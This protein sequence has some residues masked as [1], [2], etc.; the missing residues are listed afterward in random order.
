[1]TRVRSPFVMFLAL[2]V[3]GV[4]SIV[5][6]RLRALTAGGAAAAT[7]V[8]GSAVSAGRGWIALLLFFFASASTLGRWRRERRE[9]LTGNIIAKGDRRDTAQVLANGL[10]FALAALAARNGNATTWQAVGAGAIAAAIADTWATEIGTVAGGT[11]RHLLTLS[12]V[13]A[14]TSGGVTIAGTTAALAGALLAAAIVM[15]VR[16]GT[17]FLAVAAGGFAGSIMDSLLGAA[18]QERRRCTGCQI[19]TEQRVHRC[20]TPTVRVGGIPGLGND[21]VNFVSVLAGGLL[22]LALA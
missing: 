16:W 22:C 9:Q 19:D 12:P 18:V 7:L 8:G 11:P 1:M 4:L 13:P 15:A 14:G 10:V 17:P 2:C 5:A 6:Y 21:M 3:A 20:G